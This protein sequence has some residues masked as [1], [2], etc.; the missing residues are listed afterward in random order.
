MQRR[1][2]LSRTRT[3]RQVHRTCRGWR[4]WKNPTNCSFRFAEWIQRCAFRF[5]EWICEVVIAAT[6]DCR[7]L[8][9]FT[10]WFAGPEQTIY[11]FFEHMGTVSL[12]LSMWH[13]VCKHACLPL[14]I[15]FSVQILC[16]SYVSF[17]SLHHLRTD[18][19]FCY[20]LVP[21]IIIHSNMSFGSKVVVTHGV[22][23]VT[24][25]LEQLAVSCLPCENARLFLAKQ[26]FSNSEQSPTKKYGC[27]TVRI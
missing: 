22:D 16:L 26:R 10:H 27:R 20:S 8:V 2:E 5:A 24:H 15:I 4:K 11:V 19:A 12:L 23:P 7:L 9:C 3:T 1:G 21:R 14:S 25:V 18:G 17:G 13:I 6:L